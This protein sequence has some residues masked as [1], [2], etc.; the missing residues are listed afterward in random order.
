MAVG[1]RLSKTTSLKAP[2]RP[3]YLPGTEPDVSPDR[4]QPALQKKLSLCRLPLRP[5]RGA[6]E[7]GGIADLPVAVGKLGVVY[8]GMSQCRLG[9]EWI[10]LR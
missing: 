10:A 6:Q 9:G 1:C 2:L 4:A 7:A 8:E 3:S 5:Q